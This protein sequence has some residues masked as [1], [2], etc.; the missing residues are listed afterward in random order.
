MGQTQTK[1]TTQIEL[2]RND[3][4]TSDWVSYGES[5]AGSLFRAELAGYFELSLEVVDAAGPLIERFAEQPGEPRAIHAAAL[6]LARITSELAACV[7]LLRA[8]YAAQAI[9]LCGTMLE[10]THVLAYVGNDESR[11]AEWAAWDKPTKTY[12]GP[13]LDTIKATASVFGA[14]D[15]AI[16]REYEVIYRQICL[17]KHGNT[18]ALH[19]PN[20]AI[21]AD[22][23]CIV[24]GPLVTE[25][26]TRLG[27]AAIQWAI[28]YAILAEK[29]FVR[30]H[31]PESEWG[32]FFQRQKALSEEHGAL[33]RKSSERFSSAPSSP[34][35]D[36]AL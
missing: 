18:L 1:A 24:I 2:P 3:A 16:R 10:L 9:T 12:P 33:I 8:G 13:L 6:I 17:I 22:F 7:Q 30:Y 31:V 21:V 4:P 14:D 23:H 19:L 32:P 20:A 28:R 34:Q 5:R 26:F 27:H 29:A 35:E 25:D 15:D 36:S 11:A